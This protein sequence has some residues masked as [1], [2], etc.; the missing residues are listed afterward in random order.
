[1]EFENISI[2]DAVNRA[3]EVNG[4]ILDVRR[5]FEYIKG[6]LPGA[7]NIPYENI[8]NGYYILDNENPIFVYC[9]R[10]GK[11]MLVTKD[12]IQKGYKAINVV[13]GFVHY[14]GPLEY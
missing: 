6:H 1:M 11:S 4:I 7:V 12:L 5:Y 2:N 8:E 14:R 3:Y 10:G 9:D 13:G